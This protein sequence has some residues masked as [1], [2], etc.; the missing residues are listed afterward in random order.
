MFYFIIF[1]FWSAYLGGAAINYYDYNRP[2]VAYA[3]I[4]VGIRYALLGLL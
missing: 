2:I 1:V 3:H 4:F